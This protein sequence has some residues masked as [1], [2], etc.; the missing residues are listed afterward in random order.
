MRAWTAKLV[1]PTPP[2]RIADDWEA[3]LDLLDRAASSLDDAAAGDPDAE[4]KALWSLEARGQA[5]FKA[6]HLGFRVCFVK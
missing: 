6:M 5:H 1:V 4:G 2:R 3:G